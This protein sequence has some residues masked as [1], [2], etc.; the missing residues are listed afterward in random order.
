MTVHSPD[1]LSMV[2]DV[3]TILG[4]PLVLYALWNLWIGLRKL[5]IRRSVSEDCLEF[6]FKN[7]T[8]D[9]A[10]LS[11]THV[12][13]AGDIV[14]LPKNETHNLSTRPN[15][16]EV[17]QVVFM[18]G[19]PVALEGSGNGQPVTAILRKVMVNVKTVSKV[20]GLG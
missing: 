6:R 18:Y 5:R 16:Y 17:E 14:F 7:K 12:P 2:A 13:R 11:S 8:V 15:M 9:L 1:R 19:K 4:M 3:C 20:G 10:P